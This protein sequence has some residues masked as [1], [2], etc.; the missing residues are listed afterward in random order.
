MGPRREASPADATTTT[1][2]A[3]PGFEEFADALKAQESHPD[4]A[5]LAATLKQRMQELTSGGLAQQPSPD[6]Q[7]GEAGAGEAEDNEGEQGSGVQ[8]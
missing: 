7:E 1:A 3:A 4:V 2:A 5:P 6:Q 8:A